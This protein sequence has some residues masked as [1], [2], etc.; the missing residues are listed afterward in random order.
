[1]LE[2]TDATATADT[3]EAAPAP[4]GAQVASPAPQVAQTEETSAQVPSYWPEDWRDRLAGNTDPKLR[5]H[6]NRFASPEGVYKQWRQLE[7]QRNSGMLKPARPDTDDADTLAAWRKE[8][9]APDAPEGYYDGIGVD[10]AE[11][12]K[13]A[14]DRMF[15]RMHDLGVPKDQAKEVVEE[16]Y[17]M[18][19]EQ[20]SALEQNDA[21][22]RRTSEDELRTEWGPEYR[23]NLTAISVMME[24]YGSPELFEA[25]NGAR[26]ADGRKVADDPTTMKFLAGLARE[27]HPDA[28]VI[29]SPNSGVSA[30]SALTDEISRLELEMR[31]TKARVPGGYWDNPQKQDRYRELLAVR[32]RMQARGR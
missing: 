4:A 3:Q 22:F 31:D 18:A 28:N 19:T 9:G 14:L 1:M 32:D 25:L 17:R 27:L 13:P 26:Y 15:A 24:Q 29:V 2:N 30:S 12:D 6:L 11:M 8:I 21:S 7:K 23:Q 10:P 16:Y 5:Q 20:R